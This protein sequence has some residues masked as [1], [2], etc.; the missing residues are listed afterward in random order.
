[1]V[2][3]KEHLFHTKVIKGTLQG[4]SLSPTLFTLVLEPLSRYLH[5]SWEKIVIKTGENKYF[6]LNHLVFIDDIKIF[7]KNETNLRNIYLDTV[8]LQINKDK[9]AINIKISEYNYKLLSDKETYKYV[10]IYENKDSVINPETKEMIQNNQKNRNP[11]KIM[12]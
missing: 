12:A 8:G 4:D 1:M 10:E 11:S 5:N 7:A 6:T 9:S 2:N 3:G